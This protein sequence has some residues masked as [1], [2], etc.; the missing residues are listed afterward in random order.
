MFVSAFTDKPDLLLLTLQ[1]WSSIIK[2]VLVWSWDRT[3]PDT[4]LKQDHNITLEFSSHHSLDPLF[5]NLFEDKL[6][7]TFSWA[8][9]INS[10]KKKNITTDLSKG[11][12]LLSL[13]HCKSYLHINDSLQS[14]G[15][16]RIS[17]ELVPAV[18]LLGRD[19]IK[20]SLAA[21]HLER[22]LIPTASDKIHR[23]VWPIP[24]STSFYSF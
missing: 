3:K 14:P 12:S 22:F 1:L 10:K 13:I 24:G 6:V 9:V 7:N 20:I 21:H 4:L 19:P 18:K 16:G 23:W 11:L 5:F 8:G 15:L 17:L 2:V